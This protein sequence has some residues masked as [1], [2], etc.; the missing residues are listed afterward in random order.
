[1]TMLTSI[2]ATKLPSTTVPATAHL[3]AGARAPAACIMSPP[4]LP[5]FFVPRPGDG[6]A[7]LPWLREFTVLYTDCVVI[8]SNSAFFL[9]SYGVGSSS[10]NRGERYTAAMRGRGRAER[11]PVPTPE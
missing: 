4:R 6:D 3:P 1:L 9:Q 2:A 8:K 10:L 5:V 7:H 11:E